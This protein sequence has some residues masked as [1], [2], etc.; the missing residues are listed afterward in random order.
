[1][2]TGRL[3]TGTDIAEACAFLCSEGAAYITGQVIA[4]NGGGVI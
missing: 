1:V 3:G 2:P 4:V